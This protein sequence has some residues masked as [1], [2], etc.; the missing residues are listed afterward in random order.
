M[1]ERDR[2]NQ[3]Q[4]THN[5]PPPGPPDPGTRTYVE[6]RGVIPAVPDQRALDHIACEHVLE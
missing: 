2:H 6:L 4:P 5:L 3:P 1:D